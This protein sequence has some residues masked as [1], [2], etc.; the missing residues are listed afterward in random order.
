MIRG[1]TNLKDF[2][3]FVKE[4]ANDEKL[5]NQV[6]QAKT[7]QEVISIASD[8]GYSIDKSEFMN[9][10]GGIGEGDIISGSEFGTG[11]GTASKS[12]GGIMGDISTGDID[13]FNFD[14]SNITAQVNQKVS[15]DHN[16]AQNTGSVSVNKGKR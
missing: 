1:E 4:V 10:A 16:T 8:S 6:S 15:G 7:V 14:F 11:T 13:L 12:G 3:A 2:K 9:V 5:A